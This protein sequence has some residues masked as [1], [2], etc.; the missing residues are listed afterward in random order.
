MG[1]GLSPLLMTRVAVGGTFECLHDGHRSLIRKAFELANG[2]LVDIG[3]TSNKM[4]GKR[5]REIP[6]YSTRKNLLVSFIDDLDIDI[7]KYRIQQ[8]DDP[9]GSTL[10][11]EYDYIV[12]S[13][14]T[15]PVA[16]HI[17]ELRQNAGLRAIK[18][19]LVNFVMAEDNIPISS[20]RI[21]RGEIDIH[22]HITK[23]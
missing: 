5:E 7:K 6:E 20:T 21:V 15:H 3:L 22:G 14:E 11:D 12:V 10:T 23:V 16:L 2:G 4:V 13:P 17:N 19:V 1:V 9:Y 18:V 8:L